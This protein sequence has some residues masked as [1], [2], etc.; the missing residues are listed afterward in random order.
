MNDPSPLRPA[1]ALDEQVRLLESVVM[2]THDAVVVAALGDDGEPVIAFVNPALRDQTGYEPGD[3]VGRHP[4]CLLGPNADLETQLEIRRAVEAGRPIRVEI[5][6]GRRDGTEFWVEN[7]ITPVADAAGRVTHFVSIQRDI[8]A[9]REVEAALRASERRFRSLVQSATDAIVVCSADGVILY[10]SP[11]TERL[12]GVPVDR[13]LGTRAVDHV[14]R[15]DADRLAARFR[16]VTRAGS[17]PHEVAFRTRG[18]DGAVA[19]IEG[20]LTNLA[21]DPAVGGIVLNARDVSER[22]TAEEKLAHH[23]L[24]DPLT[25]RPNRSLFVDRLGLALERLG[26]H[27][28]GLVAVL[29]ADVDRFKVINDSLGHNAGDAVLV[30]LGA[31]LAGVMRPGDTVARFGGD[32]FIVLCEGLEGEVEALGIAD[33]MAE[34]ASGPFHVAGREVFVTISTGIAMATSPHVEAQALIRDA[35]AAMYRAKDGGRA[36]TA[37]FDQEMR[38]WALGRLETENA[39]RRALDRGELSLAYQPIVAVADGSLL[40]AEALLR[41]RHPTRGMVSPAEFIPVAEETGLIELIGGW[42]LEEACTQS[43]LW[44]EQFPGVPL[45]MSVNLSAIQLRQDDL[46]ERVAKALDRTGTP[47]G[48][49]CL[50]IT[51]SVLMSEAGVTTRVLA[52]LKAIGVDIAVDDFGTG[53]SSLAYLKRFPV[54]ELKVD[55]SFVKGLGREADSSA[56]VA[57]VM[58]LARALGLTSL[59]EGVENER[60]LEELRALGCERAQGFHFAVPMSAADFT[61]YLAA[62]ADRATAMARG[63]LTP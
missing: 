42:V 59:A 8:T 60:Q 33:R 17:L 34:V 11:T 49:L 1:E 2:H 9:R 56:I 61:A 29:F 13:L 31:R 10:A 12:V 25:G 27:S 37:L 57:A 47:P 22:R 55:R 50:E 40:G 21:D 48:L 6:H 32:E 63:G 15:A 41:W 45:T 39:L 38:T 19:F 46:A 26:R 62:A 3:V 53:Y 36:R 52:D 54:D 16:Q 51:E 7:S 18:A 28:A 23:A 4:G 35:D 14:D 5:L 24:H 58:A 30:E 44:L 43:Q 20:T